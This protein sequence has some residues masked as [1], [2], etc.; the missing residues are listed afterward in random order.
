[1]NY[2]AVNYC[3]YHMTMCILYICCIF[4]V[5]TAILD[6]NLVIGL[7]ASNSSRVEPVRI[8]SLFLYECQGGGAGRTKNLWL[9]RALEMEGDQEIVKRS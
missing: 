4:A 2:E 5:V 3:I 7:V 6:L 8:T 9:Y 1:M